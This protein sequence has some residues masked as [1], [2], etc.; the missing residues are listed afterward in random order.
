MADKKKTHPL[1]K[2]LK[3]ADKVAGLPYSPTYCEHDCLWLHVSPE[4]FTKKQIKKMKKYGFW[5][6]KDDD[7]FKS[8]RYGSC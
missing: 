5:V 2:A 3:L 4:N 1:I 6:D 7:C 8:G